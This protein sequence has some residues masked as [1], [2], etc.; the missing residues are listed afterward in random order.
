[1]ATIELHPNQFVSAVDF[2][3][4]ALAG[5]ATFTAVSQRTGERI[6][7]KVSRVPDFS[8]RKKAWFVNVLMGP[9]NSSDYMFLGMIRSNQQGDLW[10]WRSDKWRGGDDS[11]AAKGFKYIFDETVEHERLPRGVEMWHEGRCGRCGRK[12]T[13]PESI[14]NGLGPECAGKGM[15]E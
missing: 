2:L 15:F 1:M 3:T 14:A 7:F 10:Y 5:N 8:E 11:P 12:L 6:T 4:F 13:V 9:D